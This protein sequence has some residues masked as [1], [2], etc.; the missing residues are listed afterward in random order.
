[1]I[2][3]SLAPIGAGLRAETGYEL[4]LGYRRVTDAS[5]LAEYRRAF[6]RVSVAGNSPTV[7]VIRDELTTA[8]RRLLDTTVSV[9]VAAR[10]HPGLIIGIASSPAIAALL[11]AARRPPAGRES[12]VIANVNDGGKTVTIVA[13]NSDVPS[14]SA[15]AAASAR[16]RHRTGVGDVLIGG[17]LSVLVRFVSCS[18]RSTPA[19][20]RA[21]PHRAARG[22]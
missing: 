13:A 2:A 20:E 4:W 3:L 6:A 16:L 21:A 1:V 14:T 10:E 19:D 12:F 15:P 5:R 11:P 7:R 9:R 22:P 8:L 18:Q 17:A